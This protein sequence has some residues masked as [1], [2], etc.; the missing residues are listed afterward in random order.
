MNNS[1]TDLS[2]LLRQDLADPDKLRFSDAVLARFISKAVFHLSRDLSLGLT[3]SGDLIVPAPTAEHTDLILLLAQINACSLMRAATADGQSWQSGD[4]QGDSTSVPKQWANLESSL[5]EKYSAAIKRL[6]PS[7]SD[8]N[9]LSCG[10]L[11]AVYEQ[12]RSDQLGLVDQD[13]QKGIVA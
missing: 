1:L 10:A 13:R 5:T 8:V 9:V 2:I 3:V 6:A 11:G 7:V 12:G 4:K